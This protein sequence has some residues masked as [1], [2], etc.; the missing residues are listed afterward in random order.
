VLEPIVSHTISILLPI[1]RNLHYLNSIS[2]VFICFKTQK[3]RYSNCQDQVHC[4][5]VVTVSNQSTTNLPKLTN[6][7]KFTIKF[8]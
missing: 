2:I 4:F 8:Q 7:P 3:N 6:L 1:V 5:I